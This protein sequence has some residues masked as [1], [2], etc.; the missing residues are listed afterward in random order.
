MS[1]K[2]GECDLTLALRLLADWD[3]QLDVASVGG[4]VYEVACEFMVQGMLHELLAER[5]RTAGSAAGGAVREL[6]VT[7]RWLCAGEGFG[8][9]RAVNELTGMKHRM[10]NN[11][12]EKLVT[13]LH[14]SSTNPSFE[15]SLKPSGDSSQDLE[16]LPARVVMRVLKESL[17][18]AVRQLR[19]YFGSS[20][21]GVLDRS[22]AEDTRAWQWGAM[23]QCVFR[24]Q[25]SELV[26]GPTAPPPSLTTPVGGV[27]DGGDSGG[28]G[29][30][31][32]TGAQ[33]TVSVSAALDNAYGAQTASV[34]VGSRTPV[35]G[36]LDVPKFAIGGDT[37]TVAQAACKVMTRYGGSDC[38]CVWW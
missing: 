31:D 14:H 5:A 6:T 9:L 34:V 1:D 18:R 37:N 16:L 19:A 25:M 22:G 35:S 23:H 13:G 32:D 28:G 33:G 8:A 38:V 21:G 20:D 3:G 17:T 24:H 15:P 26:V 10:V 36:R 2:D 27:A 30:S 29:G 4:A 11:E 7:E 12:L